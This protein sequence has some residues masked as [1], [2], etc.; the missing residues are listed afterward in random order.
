MLL[1]AFILA[2]LLLLS[3][4]FVRIYV[5]KTMLNVAQQQALIVAHNDALAQLAQRENNLQ[6]REAEC[7]KWLHEA[8]SEHQEAQKLRQ[9]SEAVHRELQQKML[10]IDDIQKIYLSKLE[11]VSELDKEAILKEFHEEI[12]LSSAQLFKQWKKYFLEQDFAETKRHAQR[13]VIDAMQRMITTPN[14]STTATTVAV[15]NEEMKGRLIGREGRNIKAFELRTGVTLMIDETPGVIL[16]SCFD[17]LRR[18]IAHV[19][20]QNLIKDGRINPSNIELAVQRAEKDIDEIIVQRGVEACERTGVAVDNEVVL[21]H[22]GTLFYRHSY[23]QNTLDH[24]VE[25]AIL[26]GNIAAEL[27]LD[28]NIAKRCGL[29]HDIGKALDVEYGTHASAGAKLLAKDESSA[30]LNAIAS[31]HGEVPPESP[32]AGIVLIADALSASRPGAR[33]QTMEC[34]LERN[35]KLENIAQSFDG[36]Q[37]VYALQAGREL[38]VLVNADTLDDAETVD[39]AVQLRNRIENTLQYPGSIKI[40][41]IR[42][43]RVQEIAN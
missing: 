26:C 16:I 40:T 15:P 39:L 34:F 31:H 24:T 36:V 17:T 6:I 14:H 29:F 27:G 2:C 42:E 28:V 3:Y 43:K 37:D 32:Y 41:V 25:V 19:A 7:Q 18:E 38:R 33:T 13:I 10:A 4:V 22:L 12:K 20:L 30:V 1:A 21:K 8:Q 5:Q 35:A 9:Q 11:Q 23:G